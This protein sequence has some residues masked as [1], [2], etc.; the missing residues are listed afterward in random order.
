MP[1]RG[2]RT[3]SAV[4]RAQDPCASLISLLHGRPASESSRPLLYPF[5]DKGRNLDNTLSNH[6]PKTPSHD[7]FTRNN[8]LSNR[9]RGT[10]SS[11]LP[12]SRFHTPRAFSVKIGRAF[13]ASRRARLTLPR[14][15]SRGNTPRACL[16]SPLSRIQCILENDG[17][18]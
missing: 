16:L 13:S 7:L 2:A 4:C 8:T 5:C 6:H 17:N 11:H 18:T 9:T 15:T 3:W 12:T 1:G 14:A 10:P